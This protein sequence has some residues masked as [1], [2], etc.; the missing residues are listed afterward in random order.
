[1]GSEMCIRDRSYTDEHGKK[2]TPVIIHRAIFG[3]FERFIG[4]LIEHYAGNFPV[5]LA[6]VQVKVITVGS[7]HRNFA[8]KLH[9]Q[10]IK[11]GIRSELDEANDTVGYKIRMAEKQKVPYML[12]IGDKELKSKSLNIRIR[13]Q[14]QIKRMPLKIFTSRVKKEISQNK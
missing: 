3:T 2:Q 10:F 9:E 1:M 7:A 4:I 5:W 13:G 8:K 14:K 11:E 6:P 12:V